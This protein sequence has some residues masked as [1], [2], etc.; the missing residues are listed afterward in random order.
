M[1]RLLGN[2]TTL[3]LGS[4]ST[5]GAALVSSGSVL[6]SGQPLVRATRAQA[7]HLFI[8]YLLAG[9]RE[10]YRHAFVEDARYVDPS[11]AGQTCWLW[12]E[13]HAFRGYPRWA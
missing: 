1:R 3:L 8:R 11:M 4:N 13:L 7:S 6:M 10:E 5:I 12:A 2:G 9:K